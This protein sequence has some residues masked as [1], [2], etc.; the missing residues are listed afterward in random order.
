MMKH[1]RLG[2][3]RSVDESR[4]KMQRGKMQMGSIK[5]SFV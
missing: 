2:I 4:D 5:P 3:E 1:V